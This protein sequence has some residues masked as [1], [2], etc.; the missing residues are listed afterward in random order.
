VGF[1]LCLFRL[2]SAETQTLQHPPAPSDPSTALAAP[3]GYPLPRLV[4]D[5]VVPDPAKIRAQAAAP[6]ADRPTCS[7]LSARIVEQSDHDLLRL[8]RADVAVKLGLTG[9]EQGLGLMR[10]LASISHFLNAGPFGGWQLHADAQVARPADLEAAYLVDEQVHLSL[11]PPSVAGWN[12]HFD[13]KSQAEGGLDPS[14]ALERGLT[15]SADLSHSFILPGATTAHELH[16]RLDREEAQSRVNGTDQQSKRASFGYSHAFG[17]NSIS[18]DLAV[19]RTQPA[20]ANATTSMR[21]EVKFARP[22]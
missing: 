17:L 16:V 2:P 1:V 3:A 4:V 8:S 14:N 19:I 9:S 5:C 15:F 13:A 7:T 18:S 12:L 22:F 20:G 21:V 10:A 11:T 6:S